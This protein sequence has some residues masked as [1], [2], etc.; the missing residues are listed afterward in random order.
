MAPLTPSR[1]YPYYLQQAKK[2][3]CSDEFIDKLTAVIAMLRRD[4][5]V[6]RMDIVRLRFKVVF[7]VLMKNRGTS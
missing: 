5:A 6:I 4:P 7:D 1:L 3:K 2:Y